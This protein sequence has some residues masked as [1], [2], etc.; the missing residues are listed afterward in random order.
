MGVIK[1]KKGPYY[2]AD[3][4]EFN[5]GRRR[6][7]LQTKN[8][9]VALLKYQE[10]VRCFLQYGFVGVEKRRVVSQIKRA[11]KSA[12]LLGLGGKIGQLHISSHF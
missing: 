12:R 2:Y 11:S 6:I 4:Y 10:F 5:R 7:S 8:K 1:I 3:Y 9:Q